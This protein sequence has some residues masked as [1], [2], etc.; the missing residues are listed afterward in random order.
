MG[1][2]LRGFRTGGLVPSSRGPSTEPSAVVFVW[3]LP[4]RV[5]R[6]TV[7]Q[8]VDAAMAPTCDARRATLDIDAPFEPHGE[9]DEARAV[10]DDL[11][12]PR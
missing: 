5:C 7:R 1:N 11:V 4:E 2:S 8:I 6:F 12:L 3:P 9:V 10:T